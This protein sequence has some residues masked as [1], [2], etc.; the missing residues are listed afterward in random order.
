MAKKREVQ[1]KNPNPVRQ[2]NDLIAGFVCR[3]ALGLPLGDVSG[4]ATRRLTTCYGI[5]EAAHL[6]T[7]FGQVGHG[8]GIPRHYEFSPIGA[9][10]QDRRGTVEFPAAHL[11]P[12]TL[13]VGNP[14]SAD[15]R[16]ELLYKVFSDGITRSFTEGL[17]KTTELVHWLAN[18]ADRRLERTRRTIGSEKIGLSHVLAQSCNL[19]LQDPHLAPREIFFEK[20]LPESK[21]VVQRI[22]FDYWSELESPDTVQSAEPDVAHGSGLVDRFGR[23]YDLAPDTTQNT[24][25][26]DRL[27]RPYNWEPERADMRVSAKA[28]PE[29]RR[30]NQQ[31]V[32]QILNTYA[33]TEAPHSSDLNKI[34][35]NFQA[36][37]ANEER[38][39]LH[40]ERTRRRGSS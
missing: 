14:D 25:L 35:G 18:Y 32:L 8:D 40:R 33:T 23:P 38:E 24:G 22:C 3:D 4:H 17:F 36:L 1:D 39:A 7:Q 6:A 29:I 21:Q 20:L 30:I 31:A 27:G 15:V 11:A 9:V 28:S 2:F 19:T 26:V 12:C 16:P 37:R 10:P 13:E 34:A 5:I